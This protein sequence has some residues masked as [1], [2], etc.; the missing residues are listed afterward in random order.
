VLLLRTRVGKGNCGARWGAALAGE[1]GYTIKL[2][3]K[4]ARLLHY[5]VLRCYT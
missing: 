1:T 4:Q 5:F 3:T 2:L